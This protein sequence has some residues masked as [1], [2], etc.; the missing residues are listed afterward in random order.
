MGKRTG[1]EESIVELNVIIQDPQGKEIDGKA[2]R[3]HS[4]TSI[5]VKLHKKIPE[6]VISRIPD[7][8]ARGLNAGT[9][10]IPEWAELTFIELK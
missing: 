9:L 4:R 6:N 5:V 3:V 7:D 8:I 10:I 2:I 1:S